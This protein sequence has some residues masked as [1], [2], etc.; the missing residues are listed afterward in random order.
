MEHIT[1]LGDSLS[2]GRFILTDLFLSGLFD[3]LNDE[4]V[5]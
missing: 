3:F 5:G 4:P 2:S 1:G